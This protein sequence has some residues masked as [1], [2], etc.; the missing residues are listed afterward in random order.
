MK[1]RI[2]ELNNA[3]SRSIGGSKVDSGQVKVHHTVEGDRR[4][5]GNER[6]DYK[7]PLGNTDTVYSTDNQIVQEA[8]NR[9]QSPKSD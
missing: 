5:G 8:K 4:N 2:G 6:R 1:G 9:A 3:A 7:S